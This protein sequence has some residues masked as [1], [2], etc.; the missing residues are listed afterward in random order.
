[1][2][3]NSS[4]R[5]SLDAW[6]CFAPLA[7]VAIGWP[8]VGVAAT[9]TQQAYLKASNTEAGD[10][11][12]SVAVSGDTVVVGAAFESSNASGVDGNQN[13]NSASESGAA[14]VF[15][16]GGTSWT[17]QAYL[18]A[19]NTGGPGEFPTGDQFGFSVAVSG[20]IVVVGA[21]YE[22]SNATGV[23]GNEKDN[24]AYASGAAYVFVRNGT[25]WS[26]Q[27]YLK[28]SNTDQGDGFG[29]S[30]AVSGDT[31]VVGAHS[32]ASGATGV[33]GD[34]SDNSAF[35]SGAAYVYHLQRA[36]SVTGPWDTIDT[37]TAPA[38]GLIE[39]HETNPPPGQAF[40]RS[41]QP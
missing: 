33:N 28:A 21:F 4:S 5:W 12:G 31:A 18:K 35:L 2:K 38:S 22:S 7:A 15:V 34:Q 27:A 8:L 24:S 19:S 30:V 6:H 40:Y 25:N 9:P 32:E 20:D 3:T 1:V 37:Q 14:Y 29:G 36:T 16:R 11:F 39:Y 26:Q 13:N 41:V 23:N 10:L 17:Q